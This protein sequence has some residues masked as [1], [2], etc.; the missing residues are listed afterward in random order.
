MSTTDLLNQAVSIAARQFLPQLGTLEEIAEKAR[1]IAPELRSEE[2]K[3]ILRISKA[4]RRNLPSST[5]E[6]L[7]KPGGSTNRDFPDSRLPH[8]R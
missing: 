7:S 1:L 5:S 6:R 8:T 3:R 4:A 2:E